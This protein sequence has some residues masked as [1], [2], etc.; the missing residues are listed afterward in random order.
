MVGLNAEHQLSTTVPGDGFYYSN[1]GYKILGKI[2]EE[3]S[4]KTYSEFIDQR[5]IIPLGLAGTYS[6]WKGSDVE[7]R[8]PYIDSYLY[9][10]GKD[11]IDTSEDNMTIN[12]TEGNIVSTPKDITNWMRLLL[13]GNAGVN[14]SN[15]A[16]MKE[17]L[18]ADG[19]HGVY[20]LGLVFD[21][22]LGYGHNGAHLSY[23]SSLRYNP[24]NDIAIL[25]S[26]NFIRVDSATGNESVFEL[27]FG[28]RDACH[29]AIRE[30]QK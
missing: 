15:V 18:P 5:F 14:A 8:T 11:K 16:L 6:V 20:G 25:M 29:I 13:T 22:G 19:G 26:S 24:D 23:I 9:I 30:Y 10:R 2:I 12:V 28:I 17:M 21:E 7:M 27:G 3:I 4:G 1:T